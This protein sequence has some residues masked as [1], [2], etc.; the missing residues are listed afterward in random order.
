MRFS[1]DDVTAR[2]LFEARFHCHA[3]ALAPYLEEVRI[4]RRFRRYFVVLDPSAPNPATGYAPPLSVLWTHDAIVGFNLQILPPDSGRRTLQTV[5]FAGGAFFSVIEDNILLLQGTAPACNAAMVRDQIQRNGL[6]PPRRTVDPVNSAIQTLFDSNSGRSPNFPSAASTPVLFSPSEVFA[7]APAQPTLAGPKAAWCFE[8]ALY[9]LG[10]ANEGMQT[11][12]MPA[13]SAYLHNLS[14]TR[15]PY[16]TLHESTS[17]T[18]QTL[19]PPPQS[20]RPLNLPGGI[21][22]FGQH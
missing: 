22:R 18:T 3:A 12:A 4:L 14:G 8:D 10:I 17:S 9:N 1:R 21:G 5:Q 16:I 20:T 19:D 13:C 2:I 7:D 15:R 11:S 6:V